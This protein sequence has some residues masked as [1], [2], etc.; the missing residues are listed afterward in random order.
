M[1]LKGQKRKLNKTR[2][3]NLTYHIGLAFVVGGVLHGVIGLY[4]KRG[5]NR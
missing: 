3:R 1:N 4:R 5:Q 2:L